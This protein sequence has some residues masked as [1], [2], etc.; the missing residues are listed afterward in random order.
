MEQIMTLES[1]TG[2]PKVSMAYY[3]TWLYVYTFYSLDKKSPLFISFNS[4]FPIFC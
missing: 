3:I 4:S 2:E 1:I